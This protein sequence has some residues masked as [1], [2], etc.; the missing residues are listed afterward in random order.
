[1]KKAI[2]TAMIAMMTTGVWAANLV[3]GTQEVS[4]SGM[5]DFDTLNKTYFDINGGYGYFLFDGFEVGVKGGYEYDDAHRLWSFRFATEYNF[6]LT[7]LGL[8]PELV[9]YVGL[10]LGVGGASYDMTITEY[11][12]YINPITQE[13]TDTP[14]SVNFEGRDTGVVL[15]SEVGMKLFV[16]ED[17]ALSLAFLLDMSSG[18]I[19]PSDDGLKKIDPKIQLGMRYYF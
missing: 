10:S 19:Y 4:L 2:I 7:E 11:S 5:V 14:V 3:Q 15:G 1:M 8:I 17:F 6:D 9:P 18:D 12:T 13:Q 16:T